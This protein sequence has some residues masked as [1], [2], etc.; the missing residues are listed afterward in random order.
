MIGGPPRG[1]LTVPTV[2]AG[3]VTPKNNRR[4]TVAFFAGSL[5]QTDKTI[6]RLPSKK[7]RKALLPQAALMSYGCV[8]VVYRLHVLVILPNHLVLLGLA[9][10]T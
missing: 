7:K 6:K 9:V 3:Q 4:T 10:M 8:P 2:I 5:L 1:E